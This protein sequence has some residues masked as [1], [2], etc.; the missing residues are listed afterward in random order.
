MQHTSK[1]IFTLF[2]LVISSLLANA[3]ISYFITDS[4]TSYA[5]NLLNGNDIINST[6]CRVKEGN[7]IIKYTAY[8]VKEYGFEDG[9]VY[10]AK[11]IHLNDSVKRVFLERL[12][13]GK[14]SLYFYKDSNNRLFFTEKDSVLNCIYKTNEKRNDYKNELGNLISDCH[15]NSENYKLV[16]YNKKS[17]SKFFTGYNQCKIQNYPFLKYGFF[18]GRITT[19]PTLNANNEDE[20]FKNFNVSSANSLYGG[21]FADLPINQSNFSLL[22]SLG[23]YESAYSGSSKSEST[24]YDMLIE[25]NTLRLPILLRYTLPTKRIKAYANAGLSLSNNLKNETTIYKSEISGS[26]IEF[27]FP[28]NQKLMAANLYG[29]AYGGGIQ[30]HINYRRI[31]F[32]EVRYNK[33]F[34]FG[35]ASLL[36][37]NSLEFITG[38]NF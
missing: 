12:V 14:T 34:S 35:S 32:I 15:I 24:I 19:S 28:T 13:N 5:I 8:Q 2:L 10:I 27:D 6:Y 30:Y 11:D 29:F 9:R 31:I 18:L 38:I 33:E 23:Y 7:H 4:S 1:Y 26:I 3:Q 17:L 16:K 20:I 22:L 36:G 25:Q 37:K 21:F